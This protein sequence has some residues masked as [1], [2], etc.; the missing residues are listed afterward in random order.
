MITTLIA[1]CDPEEIVLIICRSHSSPLAPVFT[2]YYK[3]TNEFICNLSSII[4]RPLT[5]QE[6]KKKKKEKQL[7]KWDKVK[8]TLNLRRDV[9]LLKFVALRL[10]SSPKTIL[11]FPLS[12]ATERPLWI[13]ICVLEALRLV[14]NSVIMVYL[15]S[16]FTSDYSLCEDGWSW[17]HNNPGVIFVREYKTVELEVEVHMATGH[18]L[19]KCAQNVV[20]VLLML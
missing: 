17:I 11:F 7:N 2:S 14:L 8:S 5:F 12:V 15:A 4:D 9:S 18:C 13:K 19:Y 10:E 6:H 16:C 20:T 1:S 3:S